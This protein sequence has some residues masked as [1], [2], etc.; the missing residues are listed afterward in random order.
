MKEDQSEHPAPSAARPDARPCYRRVVVACDRAYRW[1]HGLDHP[2]AEVGPVLRVE[3]RRGRVTRV[4]PDGTVLRPGD[5][6]GALHLNNERLATIHVDG[7]SPRAVG[8]EFRRQF[9]ASLRTL[10]DL[11]AAGGPLSD[12]HAFSVTTIFSNGMGPR[13]GFVAEPGAPV[14]PRAVAVYQRALLASLHPAGTLRLSG[15]A[16]R[17]AQ[18]LW[19]TRPK[20]LALYGGASASRAGLSRAAAGE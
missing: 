9:L 20:L 10:A 2:D 13:L 17:R 6:I 12:V 4:L 3:V 15:S 18:R 16:H 14:W 5:R 11:A 7:R 8:L 19:L 1:F